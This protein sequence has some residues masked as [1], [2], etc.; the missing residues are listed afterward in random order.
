MDKDCCLLSVDLKNMKKT[1]LLTLA[2]ALSISVFAQ[3]RATLISET[4][5]KTTLPL[6]WNVKG[7]GNQNWGIAKSAK[8]GGDANELELFW[9]PVFEGTTRMVMPSVDLTEIPSI[10]ISFKLYFDY[11]YNTC[12]I[13]VA[14]SSDNG[15]TWNV[16]WTGSYDKADKFVVNESIITPDMGKPNVR[17]CIFYEGSTNDFNAWYFDDILVF[18]QEDN[19]AEL[20]SIDVP[21]KLGNGN[22]KISFSIKNLG[23]KNITSFEA[24]YQIE[25]SEDFVTEAFETDLE[26]YES[27]QFVFEKPVFLNIGEY[28][29]N[30][31]VTSVNG[32]NDNFTNNNIQSKDLDVEMSVSQRI[33]MIEHF[34]SSTC[35][36][37]LFT[38]ND[39]KVFT[40]NNPDKYTY[41]KY[42]INGPD[43][44]GDPYYIN[45]CG[46]RRNYY[47]V[48][49]LPM[50]FL[51][52]KLS[53]D[54][55]SQEEF[56][57]H[58]NAQSFFN[59][60]GSFS[61][62]GNNL[63]V[64]ADFMSYIDIKG[65]KAYI[66]VN[67]KTTTGNIGSNGEKEFHH[68][69]MYMLESPQG[70][71]LDFEAGEYQRIEATCD[72]AATNV[73]ELD[74]LEV[75]LW[76]QHPTTKEIYNSRFAYEYTEHVYPVQNLRAT[77]TLDE[78]LMINWDAP[79]NDKAS[80]YKI[81]IDSEL[82]AEDIQELSF[83]DES[84]S[85]N[86]YND[87]HHFI[88]VIAVYENDMT[89]VSA[90]CS[91]NESVN[92]NDVLTNKF[93]LY[94]NPV[95]DKIFIE[96]DADIE[97]I[98]VFDIYGR[99][100]LSTINSQQSLSIDVSGLNTGIYIIKINTK[101]GNIVKQFI[102]Q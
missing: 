76:I 101:E 93:H 46:I 62:N 53:Q 22:A 63:N 102:K 27:A 48:N 64:I 47:N 29:V 30:V 15:E 79:V 7:G 3:T 11:F 52:G 17:I 59:I 68:I 5:D 75:A 32:G 80:S 14:T 71:T 73:E 95:G 81:I 49:Y 40:E 36:P 33:P 1:L 70:T 2:L 21:N 89:S 90:I 83:I 19:D 8:A 16:G 43:I 37:C 20:S 12:S 28:K 69:L 56:D 82:I 65:L 38:N 86:V 10:S 91:I 45:H 25:G 60:R 9:D 97:E 92:N 31:E 61:L 18:A 41:V 78:P 51:D 84:Q 24:K 74:D 57:N 39:M 13:G 50:L 58:Y 42:P 100:Q 85:L 96:T 26:C 44:I 88:E 98:N 55:M 23:S 72:I 87:D 54:P 94:P 4:F 35:G 99:R 67:E 34:S 77:A 66:T 6:G